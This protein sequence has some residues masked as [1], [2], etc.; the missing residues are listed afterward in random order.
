MYRLVK[1]LGRYAARNG[2]CH[3]HEYIHR[4][5]NLVCRWWVCRYSVVA[6][7]T[8][9]SEII[10]RRVAEINGLV[11]A[12]GLATRVKTSFHKTLIWTENLILILIISH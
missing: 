3:L 12:G 7:A 2:T 1:Q 5:P 6:E 9:E 10:E 11:G 8:R 4:P